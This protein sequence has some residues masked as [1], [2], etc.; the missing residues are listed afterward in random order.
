MNVESPMT[1]SPNTNWLDASFAS[2][3]RVKDTEERS[4]EIRSYLN[5]VSSSHCPYIHAALQSDRLA[6]IFFDFRGIEVSDIEAIIYLYCSRFALSVLR[7]R[8]QAPSIPVCANI[9]FE[10]DSTS[11]STCVDLMVKAHWSLK[12]T[13]AT[14]QVM[15]G[16]FWQGQ[17]RVGKNGTV[18]VPPPADFISI[19]SSVPRIDANNF[20]TGQ[21]TL[22]EDFRHRHHADDHINQIISE[23]SGFSEGA[24]LVSG[25]YAHIKNVL[26]ERYAIRQTS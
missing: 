24:W 18:I 23:I 17:S 25:R 20:F 9:G 4:D 7:S 2:H 10:W 3:R 13:F 22:R 19:R 14:R 26:R 16:K 15:F 6:F 11:R 5:V 1:S 21:E 8:Q 12:A